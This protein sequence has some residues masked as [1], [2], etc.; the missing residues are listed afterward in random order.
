MS[1]A[2]NQYGMAG[3]LRFGVFQ[4]NGLRLSRYDGGV[5]R[6]PIQQPGCRH[7]VITRGH[8]EP[9]AFCILTA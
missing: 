8:W 5:E 4:K 9:W 7:G 3:C 2:G 6:G 1:S